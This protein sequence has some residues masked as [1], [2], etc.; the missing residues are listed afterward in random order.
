M[1]IF[2]IIRQKGDYSEQAQWTMGGGIAA[3]RLG[4]PIFRDWKKGQGAR[5][6]T[7][8]APLLHFFYFASLNKGLFTSLVFSSPKDVGICGDLVLTQYSQNL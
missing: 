8:R 4:H 6:N 3:G 1:I 5:S 7:H 2:V